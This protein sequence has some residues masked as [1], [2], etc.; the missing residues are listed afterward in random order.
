MATELKG[1]PVA[2][3]INARSQEVLSN[4]LEKGITPTLAIVRVGER[5][6]D[7]AYE[8]GAVKRCEKV[9]VAVS[10]VTLPESV[11]QDE[12]MG[13][14]DELNINNSVHGVLI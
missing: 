2:E 4:L 11:T 14:I 8:N 5:G 9:G 10:R 6:D 12:L 7:I 1:A 13:K 3:A